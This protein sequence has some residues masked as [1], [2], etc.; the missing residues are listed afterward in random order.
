VSE[1]TVLVVEDDEDILELLRYNLDRGGY[2][3]L[4]VTSGEGAVEKVQQS[5]PDLVLL[6][7]ML[8]GMDGLE[9]CKTLKRDYDIPIIFLTARGEENDVVIGLEMGADDYISKP[10]SPKILLSRIKAVLRRKKTDIS[11]NTTVIRI[12]DM[13]INSERHEVRLQNKSIELTLTEFRILHFLVR[14][15]GWVFTRYQ[16]VNEVHGDDYPVTERSVDV[17]IV[18]LRKKLGSYGKYI[19]TVR[20]I[21]YR[22]R[23]DL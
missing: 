7:L 22:F 3:V 2:S 13:K 8:P 5:I 23:E 19:E 12:G 20:G 14:K 11:D 18:G 21:G 10:F 17:Q 16:I 9:V 1:K 6:D 4:C 15:A